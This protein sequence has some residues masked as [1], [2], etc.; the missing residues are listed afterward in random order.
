MSLYLYRLGHWA[1][2]RRRL[3]LVFWLAV[4]VGVGVLSQAVKKDTND[5]FNVPGT[6]SQRALQI[7]RFVSEG[8]TNRE[9]ASKLFL[10]PRTVEYHLH[11]VFTKLGIASRGELARLLPDEQPAAGSQPEPPPEPAVSADRG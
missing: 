6:E 10:S 4:L 11:K 8:A 1:F 3:V 5:A 2:R 7:A 9:V